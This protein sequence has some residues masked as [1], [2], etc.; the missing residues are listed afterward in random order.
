MKV[1]CVLC[2]KELHN[3]IP[4]PDKY[5]LC[6][7]CKNDVTSV[8]KGDHEPEPQMVEAMRERASSCTSMPRISADRASICIRSL[9]G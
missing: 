3:D 4:I 6:C 1:R 2:R 7:D 9:I 5:K 8:F